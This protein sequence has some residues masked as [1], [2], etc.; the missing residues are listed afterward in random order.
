MFFISKRKTHEQYEK[1]LYEKNPHIKPREKYIGRDK[2]IEHECLICGYF[3]SPKPFNSLSGTGCPNCAIQEGRYH[4]KKTS[5]QY[6]QD[7]AKVNPNIR[8]LGEYSGADTNILH[9][10]LICG[11]IWN[12]RPQNLLFGFGCPNCAVMENGNRLRKTDEQYKQELK[13]VNPNLIPLEPYIDCKTKILHLCLVCN[14]KFMGQPQRLLTGANCNYCAKQSGIKLR[15]KSEAQVLNEI[16][17]INPNVKIRGRYTKTVNP[18]ETECL[19]CGYIWNPTVGNL[20]S[21]HGCP[22]CA[23]QKTANAQRKTQEQYIK[24]LHSIYPNLSPTEDYINS[25][26]KIN[27]YCSECRNNLSIT[28]AN[29]LQY[30]CKYCNGYYS[31]EQRVKDFFDYNNIKYIPQKKF[32]GLVGVGGK[33]LSYDF[34]LPDYNVL[35]E[36]QGGQH[37]HPVEYFGGEKQFRIQQ[38]HD[39]R[40][41]EYAK[42]HGYDL[43]EIWYYEYDNIEEILIKYLN[44]LSVETVIPA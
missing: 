40:K 36:Y 18:I 20:M 34:Y 2:P 6:I 27:H 13:S 9:K 30:G 16:A 4:V 19:I 32:D 12:A 31:G 39:K 28:P 35:C 23:I 26:A 10:C 44:F 25:N 14:Q 8:A 11:H 37:E 29:A 43:L 38:E 5:D 22:M 3:W 33:S 21:G 1:E 41:K 17:S 24:E 15:T 42:S 7:L